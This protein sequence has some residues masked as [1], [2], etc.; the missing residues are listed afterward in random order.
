MKTPLRYQVTEF[1]CG[2]T[3]L[4]NALSYVL[5]REEIPAELV[6]EIMAYTLD[7]FSKKGRES[8]GGTSVISLEFIQHWADQ[9]IDIEK[10]PL[11]IKLLTGDDSVFDIQK[12]SKLFNNKGC[13]V[14]GVWHGNDEHYVLI[15]GIGTNYIYIFDPYYLE[16]DHYL[17]NPDVEIIKDMP[18]SCNRK[19]KISQ[20]S[21]TNKEDYSLISHNP[22]QELMIIE[23]I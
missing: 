11:K 12:A 9:Y 5:D 6:H 1:D 17:N 8:E 19:V 21:L 23:R 22:F 3:S 10:L 20:L 18:F 15:T 13:M 4:L 14:A 2:T 7:N 16:S